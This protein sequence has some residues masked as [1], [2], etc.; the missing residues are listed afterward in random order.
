[1]KLIT[2]LLYMLLILHFTGCNP[3]PGQGEGKPVDT[4]NI[5]APDTVLIKQDTIVND[6]I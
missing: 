6:T 3:K 1:M 4:I 5:E 2:Y